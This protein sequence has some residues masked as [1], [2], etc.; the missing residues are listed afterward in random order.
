MD[1]LSDSTCG[2]VIVTIL[3]KAKVWDGRA[4]KS[5]EKLE[6]ARGISQGKPSESCSKTK[7]VDQ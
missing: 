4:E 6:H 3:A 1:L 5:E 7:L 2:H